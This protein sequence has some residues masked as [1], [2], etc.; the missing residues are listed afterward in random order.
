MSTS[1]T[2]PGMFAAAILRVPTLLPLPARPFTAL[3]TLYLAAQCAGLKSQV[4]QQQTRLAQHEEALRSHERQHSAD[5]Q[6]IADLLQR[7]QAL[8][9]ALHRTACAG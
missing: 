3:H 9:T 5:A 7:N 4:V 2:P 6:R 1:A 8:T